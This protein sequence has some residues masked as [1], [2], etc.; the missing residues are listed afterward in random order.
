MNDVPLIQQVARLNERLDTVDTALHLR[1]KK[2]RDPWIKIRIP[3][4]VK[5]KA[6][7]K[8]ESNVIVVW[9]G[10]NKRV[11]F[12][13][14]RIKDGLISVEGHEFG[15]ESEAIY[16]YKKWP[17]C[18]VFEWR[19]LPVGGRLEEYRRLIGDDKTVEQAKTL[20]VN[21]FG[22]QTIIRA[23]QKAHLEGTGAARKGVSLILWLLIGVGAIYAVSKLFGG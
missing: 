14:G 1:E 4:R 8:R 19:L 18:V 22:Q 5:V 10:G 21:T 13:T 15:Y 2:K 3:R 20:G 7:S 9:L 6:Q 23:I 16:H 17:L 12:K 11:D